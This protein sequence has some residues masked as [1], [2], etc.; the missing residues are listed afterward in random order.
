MTK[1]FLTALL[2]VMMVACAAKAPRTNA[3]EQFEAMM[4]Q[5]EA[6]IEATEEEW[7]QE[8]ILNG[9][10]QKSLELI[11]KNAGTSDAYAIA[12]EVL[13]M[14]ETE[15]KEQVFGYLNTDSLEKYELDLYYTNFLAEKQ[16]AVGQTYI[17]FET[18]MADGS[19]I[20]VSDLLANHPYVLIDFWASWCRPCRELMPSLKELYDAQ[21][22]QL[23][24]LGVSLDSEREK[25]LGAIEALELN[26]VHGSDLQ[27]WDD[28]NA[29]LYGVSG[30]PCTILIRASDG[31]IIARNEHDNAKLTA[32]MAE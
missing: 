14:M 2:G 8:R 25:W 1:F 13:Y 29:G 22:G 15:Q 24:I 31:K 20:K 18:T 26:W 6:A 7:E 30:I 32:L 16:T 4:H 27:G 19:T 17:D 9:F 23:E 12:K 21:N 10:L 28:R 11:E 5:T 3:Y